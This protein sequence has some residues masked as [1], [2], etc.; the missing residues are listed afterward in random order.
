MNIGRFSVNNALLV[1]LIAL[2]IYCW[3]FWAMINL[4]RDAFPNVSFD[5][6]MVQAVYAG[7][8]AEDVEKFVTIPIEKELKSVDGIKEM[9]SVSD[10]GISMI[11]L[12]INPDEKDKRK[13][14]DDIRRAV[15]R[16]QDLPEEADDPLVTEMTTEEFPI[17]EISL[18]GEQPE[19]EKRRFAETL[20]DKLE[21]IPGVA[22]IMRIGWR[23]QQFWVE[24]NPDKLKEYHV[25]FNEVMDALSSR[26]ITLPGGQ[27]TTPSVEFNIR[28]TGEFR[29]PAEVEEVVIRANDA[30]N[31]LKV[32]D[33][34]RVIDTFE[35]ETRIAKINGKRAIAMVVLKR[36]QADA[37]TVTD[38]VKKT[39][40]EFQAHLPTGMEITLTNDFSY[41]VKRRLNVL[42]SNGIQGFIF[43]TIILF[44]FMDP[45]PAIATALG[46]P[47]ALFATF[48]FMSMTG[49][50]INLITMLGF[51]IVLGMLVDDG[52]VASENVYRYLEEGMEPMQAVVKGAQ[53]VFKP[54][55]G[56]ILTTWAAF[57]PL[58]FMT[59]IIGKFI[60]AIPVIVIV[61]LAASLFEAFLVL[62][63]HLL[64]WGKY[65]IRVKGYHKPKKVKPFVRKMQEK[66]EAF[67]RLCLKHRYGVLGG[68][69]VIFVGALLLAALH[70]KII[71]FTGEGIEEFYIRAEA[72]MGIPLKAMDELIKPVESL[73][74]S[75]PKADLNA[76]RT[77]LGSIEEEGGFDPNAKRGTHLGQITVFLTP[78]QARKRSPQEIIESIRPEFEKIEG[79]EKLYFFKPKEG[80]PVGK[81][82]AV[83]IKG[84]EFTDLEKIAAQVKTVLEKTDGVSDIQLSYEF[85]KKQLRIDIDEDKAK[86]YYLTVEDIAST[87][88]NAIKGGL[89]TTIKP[90]K[91]EE[92]IDVLIRFP[93]EVRN[94]PKVFEKILIRNQRGS[95]VPFT[96]VAR[97]QETEGIYQIQ[98]LDGKRVIWVT[99]EVDNAKAT[100]LSVNVALKKLMGGIL[101]KYPGNSVKFSG[102]FEEQQSTARNLFVAFLLVLF[103]I[104]IILA[105]EF[106]SLAEPFIIM[107]TI[108]FGMIGV[109]FAFFLHGRPL[110]FF[111]LLGLVGLSGI[112]VNSSIVLIDFINV[113]RKEGAGLMESIIEAGRTRLRPILMTSFTTV[114]GLLSVAYGWG[115][116]DPFLKPMALAIVWGLTFATVLTLIVIPCLYAI[117]DDLSVKVFHRPMVKPVDNQSA[118]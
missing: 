106:K 12:T 88:R 34:G 2:F 29:S 8:P 92:E 86:K 33:V 95:L 89:A 107:L 63:S 19:S 32:K 84:E 76:Y 90:T 42:I 56:S 4:R 73:V 110:S 77:Y 11:N 65:R 71:L 26:N 48:A 79:F 78:M 13:V 61:A 1:N 96:S 9:S 20:E 116:G 57:A 3:G 115:G 23:D 108:P 118:V 50:S 94:D 68:L 99:A 54:I 45:V 5:Q 98:H 46:I 111:A 59:D 75:I 101:A 16:A 21:D 28:T 53:E 91:A 103:L 49:M 81:P 39:I 30:G 60:S 36:E 102:E 27:L 43:V 113:R 6:V 25:S 7:A 67:L 47:F 38:N 62:P 17:I 72:K 51:I 70:M 18:S 37:I 64:E 97:T 80:P 40:E 87:V 15:D 35:D 58:M 74:A 14:V 41:Y 10:E 55:M 112:V 69:I 31:W 52:I 24:L 114:A 93:E 82:V 105:Q 104:F 100:S 22:S 66:Y 117:F 44:L 109:I 83:G 85:G